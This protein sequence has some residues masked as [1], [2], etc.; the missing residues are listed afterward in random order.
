MDQKK[1]NVRGHEKGWWIV[2]IATFAATLFLTQGHRL[3]TPAGW[4]QASGA[5]PVVVAGTETSGDDD[6]SGEEIGRC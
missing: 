6:D 3:G 4:M 1:R 5:A 2:V